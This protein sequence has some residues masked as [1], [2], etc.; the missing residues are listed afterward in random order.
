MTRQ[1]IRGRVGRHAVALTLAAMAGLSMMGSAVAA[2]ASPADPATAAVACTQAKYSL[3]H[4]GTAITGLGYRYC[5]VNPDV[6]VPVTVTVQRYNA[7]TGVWQAV[8]SGLGEARYL[9]AGTGSRMYRIAQ[10]TAMSL[11]AACS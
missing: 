4:V 10:Q 1:R 11:T 7:L 3:H 2:T 6:P 5:S 8:A 9:C